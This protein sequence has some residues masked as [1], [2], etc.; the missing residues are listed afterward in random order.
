MNFY[1]DEQMI[2]EDFQLVLN[3]E[4][5]FP[6]ASREAVEVFKS[7]RNTKKWAHWTY[8]AGKADPPPDFFSEKYQLMMEVMRVDDHAYINQKGAL[9]NPVNMRE[10]QIQKE[11]RQKIKAAQPDVD[12]SDLKIMVNAITD[13]PS[14]EDHNYQRYCANFRRAL[15]KHIQ[16]IP[17]YR[18]NHPD[19][20]LVFFV[21]DES[22]AYTLVDDPEVAKRGPIALEPFVAKPVFHFLDNRFVNV[23]RNSDIDYLIWYAPYKVFHG[24]PAQLPKVCVFDVKWYNYKYNTD[25]PEELIVS[26]EA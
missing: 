17:L 22:T 24:S 5:C 26:A 25:Y 4:V 2:I 13:L 6:Y 3:S 8:N 21:F 7:V 16:K 18:S 1:D 12:F 14:N 11:I 9:I 10:S 19:K 15:E 20:K 23:F